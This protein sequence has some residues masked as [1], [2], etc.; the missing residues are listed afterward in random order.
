MDEKPPEGKKWLCQRCGNCCRWPGL[1]R[2]T[3]SEVDAIA[4]YLGMDT[5]KFIEEYTDVTPDRR[6]LTII[7]KEDESCFFLEEPNICKINDVKPIQC[8]GFPNTWNFPKWEESCEAILVKEE[9]FE[10]EVNRR[11]SDS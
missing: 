2:V 6:G 7:S 11:D 10:V 9:N 5:A 4:D 8:S 3:D 1:V